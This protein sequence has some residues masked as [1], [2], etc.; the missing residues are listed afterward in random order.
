MLP[1]GSSRQFSGTGARKRA[2]AGSA[3]RTRT[4]NSARRRVDQQRLL[5]RRRP[6]QRVR[7]A[8]AADDEG[9]AGGRRARPSRPPGPAHCASPRGHRLARQAEV[10]QLA[11]DRGGR[12]APRGSA[13]RTVRPHGD[14]CGASRRTARRRHRRAGDAPPGVGVRPGR[15]SRPRGRWVSTCGWWTRARPASTAVSGSTSSARPGI[16]MRAQQGM[17]RVRELEDRRLEGD[18]RR[19][20]AG[21]GL[22]VDLGRDRGGGAAWES[23]DRPGSRRQRVEP[24]PLPTRAPRIRDPA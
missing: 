24:C 22:G 11:A 20:I 1:N 23:A 2:I 13:A 10:A 19:A 16:E 12:P 18:Q 4:S 14:R 7:A 6:F 21:S 5:A 9:V 3:P 8:V 15:R 17:D